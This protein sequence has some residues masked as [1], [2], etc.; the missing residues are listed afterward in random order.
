MPALLGISPQHHQQVPCLSHQSGVQVLGFPGNKE[1]SLRVWFGTSVSPQASERGLLGNV[2]T[3][4]RLWFA[5][6][7]VPS[8]QNQQRAL[9]QKD[10]ESPRDPELLLWAALGSGRA[11][12]GDTHTHTESCIT[13]PVI[14]IRNCKE[15]TYYHSSTTISLEL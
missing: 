1:A 7:W 8:P 4:A 9:L 15:I 14:Y 11:A 12:R 3:P 13:A 2:S 5:P 6:S 10:M